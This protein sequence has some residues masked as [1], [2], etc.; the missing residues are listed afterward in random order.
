MPSH[1]SR[2]ITHSLRLFIVFI[3]VMD[4]PAEWKFGE[5]LVVLHQ[6]FIINT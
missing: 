3:D 6:R 1:K 4:L 2:K 5:G